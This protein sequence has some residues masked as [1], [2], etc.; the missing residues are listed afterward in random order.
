MFQDIQDGFI[1]VVAEEYNVPFNRVNGVMSTQVLE[2]LIGKLSDI[3][4][5]VME[6]SGNIQSKKELGLFCVTESVEA[7]SSKEKVGKGKKKKIAKPSA[8]DR[9]NL[10][11]SMALLSDELKRLN[12]ENHCLSTI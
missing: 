8:K 12:F 2:V 11:A 9:I 1:G 4:D 5:Q 10:S 3:Q 7:I 6:L